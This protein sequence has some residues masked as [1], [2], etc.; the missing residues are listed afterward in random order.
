MTYL[1]NQN[2]DRLALKYFHPEKGV[3]F[4]PFSLST[5]G[6]HFPPSEMNQL[7]NLSGAITW[8]NKPDGEPLELSVPAYHRQFIYDEDY[9]AVTSAYNQLDFSGSQ[10]LTLQQLESQFPGG[11]FVEFA[12]DKSAVILVF[13]EQKEGFSCI[14]GGGHLK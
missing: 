8:G 5:E 11:I 10:G 2:F 7:E 3:H 9:E 1:K 12:T 13:E 4:Y 6:R 14:S